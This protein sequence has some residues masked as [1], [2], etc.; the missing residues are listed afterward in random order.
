MLSLVFSITAYA[1]DLEFTAPANGLSYTFSVPLRVNENEPYA[2]IQFKLTLSDASSLSYTFTL[3]PA[4]TSK[5]ATIYKPSA[6]PNYFGFWCD[7]NVFS[8]D[9]L[10]GTLNFTYTG[11]APQTISITEMKLARIKE[12]GTSSEWIPKTPPIRT[13]EVSRAAGGGGIIIPPGTGTG[14]Q[15][16]G[17]Q[18]TALPDDEFFEDDEAPPLAFMLPFDD[19][20]EN[21]WFYDDVVYVY[22]RGLIK[23]VEETK[24][25][26]KISITR[27][28]IIT[29]LARY[30]GVDESHYPTCVFSDV[31]DRM[32]YSPSIEWGRQN[33][34][35]LGV[36]ENRFEPD[37][38]I[39]RQEMATI[40]FNFADFAGF[41]IPVVRQYAQ[42]HDESDIAQFAS[43]AVEALFRAEVINGRLGN[44]FDPNGIATRAEAAAMF[45]Q[46]L[47]ACE[48]AA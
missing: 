26:P 15:E 47:E 1:A 17:D 19:V 43:E 3:S 37:R 16:T 20:N 41:T 29:L 34:I 14:D 4:V 30:S 39:T 36:G 28:M 42:F 24:F 5:G 33:G 9:T 18:D 12:V 45:H 25:G 6:D 32:Y 7:S 31:D 23:G 10:V 35:L 2:G 13:I 48:P 44:V 38:A 22:E 11:N 8:G 46:Y 40:L 27:G 21:D